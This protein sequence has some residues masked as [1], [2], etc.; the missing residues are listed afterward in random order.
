MTDNKE[1]R[2][3]RL[4]TNKNAVPIHKDK[5]KREN[6]NAG[7]GRAQLGIRG[8]LMCYVSV[9]VRLYTFGKLQLFSWFCNLGC[10]SRCYTHWIK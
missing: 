3:L 9:D 8:Y 1:H 2:I 5:Q 4:S 7:I 6:H 10:V